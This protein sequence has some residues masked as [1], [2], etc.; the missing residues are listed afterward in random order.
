MQCAEKSAIEKRTPS[1]YV[2]VPIPEI[3]FYSI[4]YYI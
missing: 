1:V 2:D 4:Q 3:L